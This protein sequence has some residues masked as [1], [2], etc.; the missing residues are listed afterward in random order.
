M[1]HEKIDY[2]ELPCGDFAAMKQF[3]GVVFGWTFTDY[4]D[5]YC[6]FDGASAGLD[7][8]FYLSPDKTS[9]AENGAALIVFY[10]DDLE[11][12]MAKIEKNGG[13]IVKPVFSFPGGRRFHFADPHGNEYAVWTKN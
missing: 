10:S 9:A 2:A 1:R 5:N 6:A 4:G 13:A 3:F 8:G 11:A 7:G 12:T